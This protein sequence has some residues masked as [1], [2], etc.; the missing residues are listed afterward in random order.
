MARTGPAP[1]ADPD[2]PEDDVL[3]LTPAPLETA[4][5]RALFGELTR[6]DT[7]A[8]VRAAVVASLPLVDEPLGRRQ[9]DAV[10]LVP[11]GLAVIRVVEVL[12]QSG[13]VT[14][15]PEG[16]WTIAGPG[17]EQVLHLAGGGSSPLDGL[18]AAG[19]DTA[20]KLRRAGL[21]PGRIARLTVLVGEI[22]G[23]V[24][25]DGDLGEG[26]LVATLDPRSLLLAFARAAR[27]AG[28]ANPRL[29]TTADVRAALA[30]L[31]LPGRGPT[32]EELGGEAFPYSPYVLRRP[33]LLTPAAMAAS[34]LIVPPVPDPPDAGEPG[35]GGNAD[36]P[37]GE[38]G[39]LSATAVARAVAA[40][41]AS[42]HAAAVAAAAPT[43]ATPGLAGQR[44]TVEVGGAPAP[45]RPDAG[46]EGRTGTPDR[47][48]GDGP[49]APSGPRT[50]VLP[51]ASPTAASPAADPPAA[52]RPARPPL[53]PAWGATA[54]G[55]GGDRTPADR[56]RIAVLAAAVAAVLVV[57]VFGVWL[58][59]DEPAGDGAGGDVGIPSDAVVA[60]PTPGEVREVDGTAYTVEAVQVDDTCAGHAYGEVA[61]FFAARDCVGLSRALY[62]AQAEGA[63]VV[64]SVS[65]V[66]MDDDAAARELRALTDRDGSGNVSDL[67]REGVTYDGAPAG[68]RSAQYASAVSGS[69]VTVVESA[70]AGAGAGSA[71]AVDKVASDGLALPVPPLR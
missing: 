52:E 39:A 13:T 69:T 11:E 12:R 6:W 33:Q 37:E 2:R 64:V 20:M 10:L 7:G 62:S 15:K 40:S 42:A 63:P 57:C 3:V 60:G 24:P 18:M 26:D 45:P 65:R 34:P 35:P 28:V 51:A 58:L 19:M 17:P 54:S 27:H 55:R 68:L 30:A 44:D 48:G 47:D 9:S 50:A 66:T 5:E 53:S 22:T 71:A 25:V 32:V 46:T 14:A 29:W 61:G 23:L 31:E 38:G 41:V 70:W 67:L 16:P 59:G 49:P 1:T 21:E 4:G 56:R 36:T 43:G 8:S